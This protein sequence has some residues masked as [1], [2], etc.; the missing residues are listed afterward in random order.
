MKTP[1]ASLFAIVLAFP[2][3]GEEGLPAGN[4][5]MRDIVT[6][7]QIVE[8]ARKAKEDSPMPVFTPVEGADPTVANRPKSLL[9]R[10]DIL[11]YLGKMTLVPKRAIIHA[12]KEVSDRL[13]LKEGC[14]LGSWLDFLNANRGWIRTVPVTRAQAE[15]REPM[16][17]DTIKSFKKEKRLVIATYQDGPISVM[18]LKIPPPAATAPAVPAVPGTPAAATAAANSPATAPATAPTINVATP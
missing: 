10:S 18:P 14:E 16:S 6:H 5:V 3:A 12:P 1:V 8:A 13:G 17:E 4:V 7:D 11:C 9:E 15:G 2:A